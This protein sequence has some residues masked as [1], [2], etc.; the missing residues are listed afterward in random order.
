MRTRAKAA[1]GATTL[2]VAVLVLM[3][4]Q[5][6]LALDEKLRKCGADDQG[7]KVRASFDIP[8]ARDFKQYLPGMLDN[9]E[10]QTDAPASFVVF[11]GPVQIAVAGGL[12]ASDDEQALASAATEGIEQR[13]YDHVVC[14]IVGGT[15][16]IYADVD[17]TGLRAP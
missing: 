10:L 12:P 3:Q 7:H 5:S 14:A 8:R 16:I 17:L 9:P 6:A 13:T 1:I 2:A 4:A 11:E 15:P